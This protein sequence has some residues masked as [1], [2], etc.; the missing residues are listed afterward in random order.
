MRHL[1]LSAAVPALLLAACASDPAQM[2]PAFSTAGAP[3]SAQTAPPPHFPADLT[4]AGVRAADDHLALE[5]V[6]GAEA[7]A[8]VGQSN[9]LALASLEG[10]RRY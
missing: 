10:D 8:F 9:R 2:S 1:I 6:N 5:E 4:P 7:M 3:R